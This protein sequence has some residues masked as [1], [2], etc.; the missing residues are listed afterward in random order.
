[1][2]L[3]EVSKKA[4]KLGRAG[5]G[6]GLTFGPAL[7]TETAGAVTGRFD[8]ICLGPVILLIT[9]GALGIIQKLDSKPGFSFGKVLRRKGN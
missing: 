4:R 9:F 3:K 7:V 8:L 6:I 2:S 1:V 5:G